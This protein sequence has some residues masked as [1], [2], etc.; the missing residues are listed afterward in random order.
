MEPEHPILGF[1]I[2]RILPGELKRSGK[3]K[4]GS[5]GPPV[6]RKFPPNFKD[7]IGVPYE[8]AWKSRR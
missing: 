7:S 2:N 3:R 8:F 1:P 6:Y 5:G 4:N